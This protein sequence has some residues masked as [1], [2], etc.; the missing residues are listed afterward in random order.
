MTCEVWIVESA[1]GQYR[2]E[3]EGWS[4]DK[5][6]V[7]C[8][9]DSGDA[10]AIDPFDGYRLPSAQAFWPIYGTFLEYVTEDIAKVYVPPVSEKNEGR[11]WFNHGEGEYLIHEGYLTRQ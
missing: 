10:I 4:G 11:V 5:D 2:W 7:T 6:D 9:F 3:R 8:Y 1:K